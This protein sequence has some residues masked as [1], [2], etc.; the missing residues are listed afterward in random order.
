[1]SFEL[2]TSIPILLRIASGMV[3]VLNGSASPADWM[4]LVDTI[5]AYVKQFP[6]ALKYVQMVQPWIEKLK[7]VVTVWQSGGAVPTGVTV[8]VNDI[9]GAESLVLL[10]DAVMDALI[11]DGI[12][13]QNAV[14]T[15]D[16][17]LD[18][19]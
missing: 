17:V 5:V 3:K 12:M 7:Q 9:K 16:D 10:N 2:L 6:A 15:D 18:Q 14:V 13:A 1:M 19:A 11:A 8:S 4:G